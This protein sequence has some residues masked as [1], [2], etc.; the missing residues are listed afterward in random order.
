LD[1]DLGVYSGCV[2]AR[3]SGETISG[4]RRNCTKLA[5]W[6][7]RRWSGVFALYKRT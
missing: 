4:A 7:E 2:S 3:E 1:I 6:T 5:D